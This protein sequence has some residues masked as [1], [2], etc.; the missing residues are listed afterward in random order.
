[1]TRP[2]IYVVGAAILHEGRCLVAQRG[3]Q[4]SDAGLW[5]FPGGKVEPQETPAQALAREV[6]EELGLHIAVGGLLAR[7]EAPNGAGRLIMLEVY[8]A[9]W[10]DGALA[11]S[12]HAQARWITPDALDA[13]SWAAADLPAV[14]ALRKLQPW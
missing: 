13:L 2:A 14:E 9:R 10:L 8:L 3:P 1:M 6:E 11:L 7:G 12:E 5:E 4:M